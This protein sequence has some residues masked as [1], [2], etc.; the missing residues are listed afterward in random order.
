MQNLVGEL[1][2][3]PQ[4]E[5][6][7]KRFPAEVSGIPIFDRV[8]FQ[9]FVSNKAFLPDS[10]TAFSNRIGL[11][12]RRSYISQSHDV[13]LAWPY[14]D[15]VLEAGMTSEYRSR[16]GVFRN[17]A[18]AADDITRLFKPKVLTGWQSW[19]AGAVADARPRPA[20]K[21]DNWGGG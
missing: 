2:E 4:S 16:D 13:V 19:D 17:T 18:P 7:G 6:I 10:C 20:V 1:T 9:E 5:T 3:P 8:K 12:D 11:T 14:K 15:C 21:H